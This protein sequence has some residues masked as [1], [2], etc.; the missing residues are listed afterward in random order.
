[1]NN[2]HSLEKQLIDAM[3]QRLGGPLAESVFKHDLWPVL[4]AAMTAGELLLSRATTPPKP[5]DEALEL[6][7]TQTVARL[8]TIQT[9]IHTAS[10]AQ[11]IKMLNDIR[12]S[13]ENAL[14]DTKAI[15]QKDHQIRQACKATTEYQLSHPPDR[16][17][18]R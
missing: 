5:V 11:L 4:D 16:E 17:Y 2:H 10:K 15:T 12:S 8:E 18:N 6:W 1:M 7:L 14:S 9:Y 3:T 13:A